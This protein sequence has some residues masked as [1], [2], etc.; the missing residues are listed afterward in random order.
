MEMNEQALAAHMSANSI[1]E[2]CSTLVRGPLDKYDK[3]CGVI[4][5]GATVDAAVLR[6]VSAL[7]PAIN[8]EGARDVVDVRLEN[9]CVVW[10][11]VCFRPKTYR[12]TVLPG[13]TTTVVEANCDAAG[14][15]CLSKIVG[16][17]CA[18]F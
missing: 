10:Q 3:T 2:C 4:A 5:I 6:R 18:P 13:A 11:Q 1:L 12:D 14:V 8:Y 9:M 15:D 7:L 17:V 16:V